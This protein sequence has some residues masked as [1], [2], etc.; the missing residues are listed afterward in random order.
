MLNS[1]ILKNCN[2]GIAM[3]LRSKDFK[4]FALCNPK[5]LPLTTKGGEGGGLNLF[6]CAHY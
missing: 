5:K 3:L 4:T 1:S 2:D 6:C